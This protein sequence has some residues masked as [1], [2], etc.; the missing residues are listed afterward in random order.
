MRLSYTGQLLLV[1]REH[2]GSWMR[3]W[4][5]VDLETGQRETLTERWL[6]YDTRPWRPSE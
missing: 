5:T 3:A 4:D 2:I 6:L 1:L